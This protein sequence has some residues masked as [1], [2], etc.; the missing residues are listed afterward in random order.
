MDKEFLNKYFE[1]KDGCLYKEG[2]RVGWKIDRYRLVSIHN[3]SYSEHRIIFMM[4]HG[5]L[6]E[7]IDHIDGDKT[8]NKIENLRTANDSENAQNRK[9]MRTNTSGAKNVS[10][11]KC[12]KRWQVQLQCNGRIMKFGYFKNLDDAKRVAEQAR[13][14]HHKE[15][16]RSF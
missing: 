11:D 5:Y 4:H 9:M 6:P 10:W 1:Y 15:F 16:A 14:E 2:K 3:K 8:N 12:N 13:N 7:K